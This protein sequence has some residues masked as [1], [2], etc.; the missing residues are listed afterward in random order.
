MMSLEMGFVVF[1]DIE[2]RPQLHKK[3]TFVL[4]L[5]GDKARPAARDSSEMETAGSVGV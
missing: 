4:H 5:I 2:A 3:S 1:V